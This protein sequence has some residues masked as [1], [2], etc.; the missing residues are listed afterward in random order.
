M[1]LL[2]LPRFFRAFCFETTFWGEGGGF[3]HRAVRLRGGAPS[4]DTAGHRQTAVRAAALLIGGSDII[5]THY[6]ALLP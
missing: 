6:T 3:M 2:Y 5:Y 1:L 4:V